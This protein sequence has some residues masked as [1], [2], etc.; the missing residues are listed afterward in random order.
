MV[1]SEMI[2]TACEKFEERGTTEVADALGKT[3]AVP[4]VAPI[5]GNRQAVAGP[6][7]YAEAYNESNW[8]VHEDLRDL[9]PGHVVF[10][11]GIDIDGRAVLGALVQEYIE[12][13]GGLGTIVNGNIRDMEDLI[14]DEAP[15][16]CRGGNPIGCFNKPVP[17]PTDK[18]RAALDERKQNQY[19]EPRGGVAVADPTGVV[20]V[21][22]DR[23]EETYKR[24]HEIE[25][26]EDDWFEAL[27]D[28]MDT[29]EIVCQKAY[30]D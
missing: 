2:R 28:G 23:I 24:L 26:D 4:G 18:Q 13:R 5:P 3:G 11:E 20:V 27:D 25:R 7:H 12:S 6:I 19:G 1:D 10:V 21:P 22:E 9:K 14:E 8:P 29:Y 15:V 17:E 16:W 30:K